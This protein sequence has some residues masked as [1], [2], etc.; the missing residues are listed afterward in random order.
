MLRWATA[1]GFAHLF[2]ATPDGPMVAHVP[3]VAAGDAAVR[4]HI[5]RGN[6]LFRHL[7]GARALASVTG[8]EGYVT[9]NWYSDPANQVPTWNYVAV[10]IE[11]PVHALDD[12]GL[13]AQLDALAA[14]HEPRV[15]P[16]A[17]WTRAKM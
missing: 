13:T 6:R 1:T 4:F 14:A 16:Q 5:A 10:E 8:A 15:S 17:P 12:E 3:I 2:V 11:G 7:G 9:P